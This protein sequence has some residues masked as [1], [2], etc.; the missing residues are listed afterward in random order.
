MWR[1]RFEALVLVAQQRARVG[2]AVVWPHRHRAL[3][4]GGDRERRVD[5]EVGG[6]RRAV[7]DVQAGVAVEAVVGVDD[8]GVGAVADRAAAEEVR[9]HRDVE[10]VA[11]AADREAVDVLGDAPAGLVGGWNPGRIG[12]PVTL[13]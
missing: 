10:D 12:Q 4:L 5:A 2:V 9:G 6:D 3:G 8:A 11:D 1:D 13:P 7:D